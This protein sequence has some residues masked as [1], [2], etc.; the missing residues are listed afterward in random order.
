MGG[1]VCGLGVL[2]CGNKLFTVYMGG[3][4]WACELADE[5]G[6]SKWISG[7][8]TLAGV[9]AHLLLKRVCARSYKM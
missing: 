3:L 5:L 6:D 9:C 4:S 7:F 1:L 2:Q 8:F